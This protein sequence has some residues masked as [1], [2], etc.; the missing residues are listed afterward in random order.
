[1]VS[2]ISKRRFVSRF[3]VKLAPMFV[4]LALIITVRSSWGQSVRSDNGRR[5][6]GE[7]EFLQQRL[8][9]RSLAHR[10]PLRFNLQ[11]H[12]AVRPIFIG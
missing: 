8:E 11:K 1:M 3:L 12:D 2:S 5:L 4:F 10:I 9:S 6:I 7:C